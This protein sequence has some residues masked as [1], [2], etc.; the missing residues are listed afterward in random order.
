MI[1]APWIVSLAISSPIA[2]GL[3]RTARRADTPRLCTFYNSD[4]LIYSS[5][6]S[7]YVPTIVMMVL[8]WRVYLVIRSRRSVTTSSTRSHAT[9]ADEFVSCLASA[10]P[11]PVEARRSDATRSAIADARALD[12]DAT[13]SAVAATLSAVQRRADKL[14]PQVAAVD[15]TATSEQPAA[16]GE[17]RRTLPS[18]TTAVDTDVAAKVTPNSMSDGTVPAQ[19]TIASSPAGAA[20]VDTWDR[21]TQGTRTPDGRSAAELAQKNQASTTE[22]QLGETGRDAGTRRMLDMATLTV[23]LEV[24]AFCSRCSAAG[25]DGYSAATSMHVDS[26]DDDNGQTTMHA[27]AG[28]AAAPVTDRANGRFV[29]FFNFTSKQQRSTASN[30]ADRRLKRAVRRERR[31]TKTL[32]IVLGNLSSLYLF[33]YY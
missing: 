11:P 15:G 25:P 9:A 1:A 19:L 21:A 23:P 26:D 2:L 31:A 10:Q 17:R 14:T 28:P 6:G 8:Y 4:F 7:F 27:E 20:T 32:A 24:S 5:M 3:N 16:S 13:L 12:H 29:T 33:I 18:P 22:Q 30:A